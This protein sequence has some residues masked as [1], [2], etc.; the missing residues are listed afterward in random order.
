MKINI[1][2]RGRTEKISV[3]L[4]TFEKKCDMIFETIFDV[5]LIEVIYNE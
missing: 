4:F 2:A 5:R 3:N 1:L